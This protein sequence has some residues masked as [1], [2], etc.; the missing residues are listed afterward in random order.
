MRRSFALSL[1]LAALALTGCQSTPE[2][3]DAARRQEIQRQQRVF[4]ELTD[5]G[6]ARTEQVRRVS[7]FRI[8]G[9]QALDDRNLILRAGVRD[10]YLVTLMTTC[11]GLDFATSIA[12]DTATSSLGASD[13]ILVRGTLQAV[14]R[15]PIKEIW[16]LEELPGYVEEESAEDGR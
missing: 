4:T 6:L 2:A 10:R 16:A 3:Q 5:R 9:W 11:H 8:S 14:E 7:N 15:C 1:L 13:N 12:V